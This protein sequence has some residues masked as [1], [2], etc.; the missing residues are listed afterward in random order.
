M[1]N[2]VMNDSITKHI[3]IKRHINTFTKYFTNNSSIAKYNII[4]PH[5]MNNYDDA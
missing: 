3:T 5:Q 2:L 1:M 4:H